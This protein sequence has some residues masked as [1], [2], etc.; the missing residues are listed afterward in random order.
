MRPDRIAAAVVTLM[1]Y[2][3]IEAQPAKKA[4]QAPAKNQPAASASAPDAQKVWEK[5]P[6]AFLGIQLGEKFEVPA[7]PTTSSGTY[8]KSEYL[9]YEATKALGHVCFDPTGQSMAMAALKGYRLA[10]LP[11][12]GIGYTAHAKVK[13]G[14]VGRIVIE[15]K[16]R[17]FGVL[18]DAFKQRYGTPT[19]EETM[20]VRNNAGAEFSSR[21]VTWAGKKLS[22]KML[23]RS[24]MIDDSYV[25][26]ADN[27]TIEAESAALKAKRSAEAQKF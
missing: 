17:S 8:V 7:C 22:I 6:A 20:S 18:L 19:T 3:A 4:P 13:D 23:E 5:E 11:D 14:I 21:E 25:L 15:L 27:A 1:M 9:D 24:S 16:Q 26:I 2:A 10:N 12:L